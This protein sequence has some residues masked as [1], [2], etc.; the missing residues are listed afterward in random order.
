MT[1]W[2]KRLSNR[3]DLCLG[4]RAGLKPQDEMDTEELARGNE[5]AGTRDPC[6]RAGTWTKVS[7]ATKHKG[8]LSCVREQLEP[9]LDRIHRPETQLT[10]LKSRKQ[11]Q[12]TLPP[13]S[14]PPKRWADSS[15][16]PPGA[17][18]DPQ[19]PC[20]PPG[21]SK[22]AHAVCAPSSATETSIKSCPN[23]LSGLLSISN[24]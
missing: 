10:L 20:L 4:P 8:R 3:V 6:C 11:K 14:A 5:S 7:P 18:L 19:L 22:G 21:A 15:S 17:A 9:I 13:H 2:V 16:H 12:G 24:I 1:W 23:F